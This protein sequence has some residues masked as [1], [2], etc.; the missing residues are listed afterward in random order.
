MSGA[1]V[2]PEASSTILVLDLMNTPSLDS[3][4]AR[5]ALREYLAQQPERLASPTELMVLNNAGLNMAQTYTHNRDDLLSSLHRVPPELPYK[6]G[7][8]QFGS[9]RSSLISRQFSLK[10][11]GFSVP[12]TCRIIP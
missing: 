8:Q 2:T 4:S 7:S 3:A 1:T 9:C 6:L 12:L 11:K 10:T 5:D